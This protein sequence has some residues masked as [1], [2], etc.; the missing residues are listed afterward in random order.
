VK[1][2]T[3]YNNPFQVLLSSIHLQRAKSYNHASRTNSNLNFS[4]R[5]FPNLLPK[6]LCLSQFLPS[7]FFLY[8][9]YGP[10]FFH[11]P[12]THSAHSMLNLRTFCTVPNS[13]SSTSSNVFLN[14]QRYL[15]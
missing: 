4:L 3:F 10:Y 1:Y 2:P 9:Y 7:H 15:L 11:M 12:A 8:M 6:M 13:N 14:L 5:F